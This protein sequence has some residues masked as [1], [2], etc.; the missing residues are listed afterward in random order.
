MD[1]H[2]GDQKSL[3]LTASRNSDVKR[4]GLF[5]MGAALLGVAA[6]KLTGPTQ[7]VEAAA[8][9][10]FILGQD[11]DAGTARTQLTSN[12]ANENTLSLITNSDTGNA[13]VGVNNGNGGGLVGSVQGTGTA[14][15]GVSQKG[16]GLSGTSFATTDPNKLFFGVSGFSAV[17]TGVHGGTGANTASSQTGSGV[18]GEGGTGVAG[19]QGTATTGIGVI[20]TSSSGLAGQFNGPVVTNGNLTVNGTFTAT[21]IKS[22]AVPSADGSLVRLYCLESPESY[23][24]D[25]GQGTLTNGNGTVALSPDFAALVETNSALI[26]MTEIGNL[27][28]LYVNGVANGSFAI[29]SRS[30]SASGSFSYRI[31]AKR[32]D[33]QAPRL[34]DVPVQTGTNNFM[35]PRNSPV[36]DRLPGVR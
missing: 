11:N 22:A 15:A 35:Q 26:F 2:R 36:P 24:E 27:G 25:F 23:F 14:L 21:G 10:N 19:V 32:K 16:I 1:E 7:T 30:S 17:G 8:G 5:A 3:T 9:G 34:Q 20:G 13:A 33:V 4:R 28:G 12:V 31:V 18:I 29:A 6:A